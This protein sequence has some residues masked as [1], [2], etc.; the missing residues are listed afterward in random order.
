M[1]M[2]EIFHSNRSRTRRD[3]NQVKPV[4]QTFQF[5]TH[6]PV[7]LVVLIPP[8]D[9]NRRSDTQNLFKSRPVANIPQMP[10]L[11]CRS[12]PLQKRRGEPIM[13]I[14]NDRNPEGGSHLSGSP[15][16]SESVALF[17]ENA[18]PTTPPRQQK[19]Q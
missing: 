18:G 6:R 10:D 4:S 11:I 19:E 7:H 17:P 12:D 9:L 2:K 15:Q 13:R 14:G 8:H 5:Q 3:M 16:Q 1:P